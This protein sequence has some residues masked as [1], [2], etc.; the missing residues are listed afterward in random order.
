MIKNSS[1]MKIPKFLLGDNTDHPDAI[2]IVHTEY[3]RFILNLE[4]DEVEWLEEFAPE[5]QKDLE[6]EAGQ[7][8]ADATEFYDR[9]VSRYQE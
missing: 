4:N 2:Y 3:P 6:Q 7:L 8:I 1:L 5:D 9:E